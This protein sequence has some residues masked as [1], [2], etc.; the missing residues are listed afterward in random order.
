TQD[1]EAQ[2]DLK[3]LAL[4]EAQKIA[5][6]GSWEFNPKTER[7]MWSEE[8]YH[9]YE[10]IDMMPTP[11]PDLTVCQLYPPDEEHYQKHVFDP[12]L[13]GEPF[14]TDLRIITQKGNLRFI[15]AQGHP[16]RNQ[17][18]EIE[19]FVGTMTDITTR[20]QAEQALIEAKEAAEAANQAKSIFLANMS[21]E[22]R[23]PLNAILGYP[24]LLLQSDNLN[25]QDREYIHTIERS[26]EYLLSLINQILDLSKIEAG[27]M[28]LNLGKLQLHPLLKDIETMLKPQ[29]EAK[30]LCLKIEKSADLP[31]LV[32]TDGVKLQQVLINILNNAIKFT[33][34]GTVSLTVDV[35]RKDQPSSGQGLRFTIADTGVGIAPA[36]L[37]SLFEAFVQ[38]ESGRKSNAGTGLGLAISQKFVALMGGELQVTSTVGQGTTFMFELGCEDLAE[39]KS[40]SVP[41]E[42]V[43]WQLAKGQPS[44]RILVVDDVAENRE[45]LVKLLELWG[46]TVF[47]AEDGK[48]AITKNQ[49]HHPDL[50]FM[51]MKMPKLNGFGAVQSIRQTAS[52]KIPKIIAFTAS[53]FEEDRQNILAAGCD[54][55]VRK[56]FQQED[57][58]NSLTRHLDAQF[59]QCE[60]CPIASDGE[61]NPGDPSLDQNKGLK[62]LQILIAEDNILNQK[63]LLMHLKKLGYT[64]DVVANGLE[65]LY[66]LATHTYDVIL[67]DM[68]MPEMDGITATQMIRQDFP[69][70]VQ[71]HIIALTAN[72][73]ASDRLACQEAGMNGYVT[74]PIKQAI[75]A[76]ALLAVH[77][78]TGA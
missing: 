60:Y 75:L 41:L 45:I 36:E 46:L 20:K 43:R 9:I 35:I 42:V 66:T 67:M 12:F 53:A 5:H 28:V 22:L 78:Q 54:D 65:V 57:I 2:V 72:D 16:I 13:A 24:M 38:T 25:A 6:M 39:S 77:H 7:V 3:T 18:G 69:A 64:A 30:G 31:N 63:V 15:H 48:E 11:R 58:L 26:G 27:R 23:T 8:L 1:L 14:D 71:P 19:K 49:Q 10:A 44:Y 68:Q 61:E 21:H 76:E 74:K 4:T 70:D 34:R 50:I 59:T 62:T 32:K 73:D 40:T 56:P 33:E 37:D 52:N 51:D 55:F 47:E 17:R 29:A